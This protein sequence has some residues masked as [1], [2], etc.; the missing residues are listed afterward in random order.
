M[1]QLISSYQR[2]ELKEPFQEMAK[3][4]MRYDQSRASVRS[5]SFDEGLTLETSAFESLY[6]G[7]FTL[8]T[9]LIKPNDLVKLNKSSVLYALLCHAV[10][11]LIKSE[12]ERENQYILKECISTLLF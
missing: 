7:Q 1:I 12:T 9:L 3:T 8:S 2:T 4:K 5:E 10:T 11:P 6:G